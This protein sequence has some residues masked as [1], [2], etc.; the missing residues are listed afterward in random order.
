[1]TLVK[2]NRSLADLDPYGAF[3][4]LDQFWP[5]TSLATEDRSFAPSMDVTETEKEYKVTLETPGVKKEDISIEY[6][7][8]ILTISGEKRQTHEEKG[9]K[10]Y[11]IERRYGGFTRSL[12]FKDIDAEKIGAAFNDGV[13]EVTV[14]KSE[15]AQPRKISVA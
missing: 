2:R 13:L 4:L 6:E 11:R 3:S 14:P 7:G 12:R 15:T 8:G 5:G 9:E 1:M 10:V